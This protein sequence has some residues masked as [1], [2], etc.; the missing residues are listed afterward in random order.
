MKINIS[1]QSRPQGYRILYGKPVWFLNAWTTYEE[2]VAERDR[3]RTHG[4]LATVQT[5]HFAIG[6]TINT[7]YAVYTSN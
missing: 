1:A 2:A 3:N 4:R 6:S 5:R 7:Y